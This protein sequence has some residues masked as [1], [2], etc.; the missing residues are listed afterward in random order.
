MQPSIQWLVIDIVIL[1]NA[2]MIRK[3]VDGRKFKE[4]R[5]KNDTKEGKKKGR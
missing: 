4:W 3:D 1:C 5:P 2:G